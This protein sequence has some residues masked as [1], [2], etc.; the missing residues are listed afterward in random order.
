[1]LKNKIIRYN[2]LKN[3]TL[4]ETRGVGFEDV[5][6]SIENGGL[7]DDIR[8][9]NKEKYAHQNIFIILIH[10]K[11]YIYL[12]PYVENEAEIFLKTI[13]PSRRMNKKYNGDQHGKS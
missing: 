4:K 1:M 13:I 5:I 11:D 10:I 7:L 9:Y 6:L 3:K 12:V 8:H 2:I